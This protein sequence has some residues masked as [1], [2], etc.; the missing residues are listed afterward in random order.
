MFRRF[1]LGLMLCSTLTGC[2]V[3][4]D[5]QLPK[6]IMPSGWHEQIPPQADRPV[7]DKNIAWWQDFNDPVLNNLVERALKNNE[8]LQVAVA[9][10]NEARGARETANAALFPHID[11]SGSSE[12]GIPGITAEGGDITVHQA[13]FDATWELDLFG[14]VRRQAQAQ[15]ALIGAREAAYRNAALSLTAEVVREYIMLRQLQAQSA[16]TSDTIQTQ[17][18]LSNIAQDRYK[19]GLVS[20]LDVAQSQTLYESTEAKLP[21]L[22][23]QIKASSYRLSVL[24]GENPGTLDELVVNPKPIP[25][26][27]RIP[28][29]DAPADI[30]RKR[31]DVA[32]AERNLAATTA[33]QGVAISQLYP[34]ISLSALFGYQHAYWPLAH[35]LTT[36]D[37]WDVAGNVS[38]PILEFGSIEGQIK[39]ADARQVEAFHLYKQTVLA[40]LGDV[41][42]DLSNLTEES[43]RYKMLHRAGESADKAV[44]V[45]HERYRS[46]LTD[47]TTVLQA[48]QQRF[49]VQLDLAASKSAIAQ[50][51][52]ALHK[53]LGENPAPVPEKQEAQ[54]GR[55]KNWMTALQ[56]T[57][58]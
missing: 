29:L 34:N 10:I 40:A 23:L 45:A 48:E 52:V 7:R 17:K 38:M 16:I 2:M 24:L 12:R 39:A 35:Y 32:E 14:G 46:G 41:E 20:T 13:A 1:T 26:E 4:P 37:I 42:T 58:K 15:D 55:T 28:V 53:A 8:N 36:Q 30:I 5:Y 22:A 51:I 54:A 19:G 57:G 47:F 3:G 9:R 21:Q 31:P 43:R 49:A 27:T 56:R 18:H 33:L 44:S 25:A 6:M 11:A 50:D